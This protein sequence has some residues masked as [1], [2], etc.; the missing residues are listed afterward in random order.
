MTTKLQNKYPKLDPS[1]RHLLQVLATLAESVSNYNLLDLLGRANW[2][3]PKGKSATQ[4]SFR[5]VLKKLKGEGFLEGNHS[6]YVAAFP[7]IRD[8]AVQDALRDERFASL[9]EVI[10]EWSSKI[11]FYRDQFERKLRIAFYLG[12]VE[13]VSELLRGKPSGL[14]N[15]LLNP[16]DWD[17]FAQIDPILQRTYLADV[18]PQVIA[19]PG[20]RPEVLT[21][22][23]ELIKD[24][25]PLDKDLLA[26]WMDLAIARGDLESLKQLDRET[27]Q[28]AAEVAGC[29]ALLR[30]DF[31][32]AQNSLST[33]MGSGKRKSKL[34]AIAHLPAILYSLLLLRHNTPEAAAE[35]QAVLKAATRSRKAY[36]PRAIQ[37]LELAASFRQ[38]VSSPQNLVTELKK[39]HVTTLENLLA[40]YVC[41][42]LLSPE[43][44]S[45]PMGSFPLYAE[46]FAGAG[47][48]WFAAE[49][50]GVSSLSGLKAAEK[51]AKEHQEI[52][53]RLGTAT[54]IH[55][56]TPEPVW[57]RTLNAIAQL[58]GGT[59]AQAETATEATDRL[60]W[61]LN[62]QHGYIMLDAYHQTMGKRGWTKGRKVG[63]ERLYER[64]NDPE[65]AFLA[66]AD[67]AI[68][69]ALSLEVDRNNWGYTER[70]YYYDEAKVARALIGHPRIYRVGDRDT[71][72]EIVE[73]QPKLVVL[74]EDNNQIR[75]AMDPEPAREGQMLQM[76]E[77]GPHRIAMCLFNE[78]HLKLHQLLGGSLKVPA[79]AAPK[80]VEA[81]QPVSSLVMVQSEIGGEQSASERVEGDPKPHVHLLPY[82]SGIRVEFFVRPFGEEGPFCRPGQGGANLLANLE[83][84]PKT[85]RRN[86]DAEVLQQEAVLGECPEILSRAAGG[87]SPV[88]PSPEEALEA[89][90]ELEDLLENKRIELHWPKGK[91][92]NLAGRASE[93]QF[94][95]QIKKDRD[96]F[97]ASG[98]LTVNPSL[99]LDMMKLIELV[100]ASPSRFVKMDDGS[101]LALTD[102]LRHRI[103]ELAAYGERR[104]KKNDLRFPRVRAVVMDDLGESVKLKA[105]KHWKEW[106]QQLHDSAELQPEVPST[107]LTELRDYQLEGFQWLVRLASWGVGACLA[108]DMG[109]GKTIQGLGLM[110]HRAAGGPQL[111]V[112]PTSVA[113]NWRNE[114]QRF[115]PTLNARVFG[116]SDREALLKDLGPRD[117]V[118]CSYGL[119]HTEAERLQAQTWHTVI[120]DEAQAIKNMTTLR[121]KAAM[122]LE[123]DFRMI[124]TGTPVENHLGELWNLFEFINPGLLGS[125]DRFQTRFIAP[126]ERNNCRETKRR[127]KK[128]IQPFTLRRTK[129]QV[130][131]EL[132]SRTE[133]TLQVELSKEEAT[134]YE[135][136]RLRAVEKLAEAEEGQPQHL[137]ILAEIMRLRRACCHP[138]LVAEDC[139]IAGSK[140]ALFSKTVDE[141]LANQH[142][143]LVFSQFVDHLS[144]LREELDRKKISYQY[145]DGSTTAR[146]REQR[147]EAFQSGNGDVFLISLKAGGT[148]LN[149]TAAD[150]VIHMDP[151]WNPAVEDQASDRAHRM[152]QQ[153][154]VTIY[155][156][157]AKGTIEDRILQLHGSKRDLADSLLEGAD[158]SGKLSAEELLKL[159]RE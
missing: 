4:G 59:R 132:P 92:L 70:Y 124:M 106:V 90:L 158:V 142:K 71:P 21:A 112:A 94:Q 11:Y 126:I 10:A 123:A 69:R 58:G 18:V 134:F 91:S 98:T 146:Q 100:E 81:I 122:A 29:M 15:C 6:G 140:L 79:D 8:L 25:S 84:K 52:H 48:D 31:D 55:L 19:N 50:Y 27:G 135:S 63:K 24:P 157:I 150:Y 125:L 141:L 117:L 28:K 144:I 2:T 114:A 155:R 107:L 137:R 65:F 30:G 7:E 96:W 151:W 35:L 33:V 139:G 148:G 136:L 36:Y 97:A 89:L 75:L 9:C 133:V 73:H 93:S 57:Q 49:S 129:S 99:S 109:L 156:L 67:R 45:F 74:K 56:L 159:L 154:P 23:E 149:L 153:R 13:D 53:A 119:L 95:V 14:L 51:S 145:L 68:C 128:L 131:A 42:W 110:L 120:L 152:G 43:E 47:L 105:D 138:K 88:F 108:D 16:F 1:S 20:S 102:K 5:P 130:L 147:V 17:I 64:I 41:T 76:I 82:Q 38:T 85:A 40:G 26:T 32:E 118:I 46:S 61:E 101:F 104:A 22:F 37:L 72:I 111:V 87:T 115:A 12:E 77:E 66:E 103:E 80:V 143:V 39:L 3:D 78:Q 121:S 116:D 54:L 34:D 83:G 113:Y 62:V 44:S 60:I 127:L 86:L